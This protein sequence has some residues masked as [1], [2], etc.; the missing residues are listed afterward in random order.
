[1]LSAMTPRGVYDWA[2]LSDVIQWRSEPDII[3]SLAHGT[4]LSNK[5]PSP[6]VGRQWMMK[7]GSCRLQS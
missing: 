7:K 6:R 1:M 5:L 2:Q 4:F 3:K